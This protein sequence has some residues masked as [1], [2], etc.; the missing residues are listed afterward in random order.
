MTAGIPTTPKALYESRYSDKHLHHEPH[1]LPKDLLDF[2]A[3]R[4]DT[5][6][7]TEGS[8]FE[9][10]REIPKLIAERHSKG[11]EKVINSEEFFYPEL[12]TNPKN[13][14]KKVLWGPG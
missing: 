10:I 9:L 3:T 8:V 11:L 7:K 13:R 12:F 6:E 14:L 1:Q 2:L 5:L 4:G